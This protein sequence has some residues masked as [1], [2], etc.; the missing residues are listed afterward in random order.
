MRTGPGKLSGC[1]ESK[2]APGKQSSDFADAAANWQLLH[3]TVTGFPHTKCEINWELMCSTS[4][5]WFVCDL[6]FA[7]KYQ[8]I[9]PDQWFGFD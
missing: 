4:G 3:A 2:A 5:F 9:K 6:I 8:W 1:T 7:S